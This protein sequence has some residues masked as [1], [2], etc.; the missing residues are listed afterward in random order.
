MPEPARSRAQA[1]PVPFA[2]A[3]AAITAL[4]GVLRIAYLQ[5]NRTRP[6]SADGFMYVDVGRRFWAGEGFTT[7]TGAETALHPPLW[8]MVLGL[9]GRLGLDTLFQQQLAAAL[10]GTASI[11]LIGLVGREVGGRRIGLA[12]A[13]IAAFSPNLWIWER[14]LAAAVPL[15][16]LTALAVLLAHRCLRSPSTWRFVALGATGGLLILTRT[17]QVLLLVLLVVGVLALGSRPLRHQVGPVAVA[18]LACLL[19]LAPWLVYNQTRF[20]ERVFVAT[21]AGITLAYAN[22]PVTYHGPLLGYGDGEVWKRSMM[23]GGDESQSDAHFREEAL[24][25]VGDNLDRLPVVIAARHGRTWGLFRPTQQAELD[26]D[27]GHSPWWTYRA[28]YVFD[29]ILVPFA[30]GGLVILRRRRIPVVLLLAPLAV[31]LANVTVTYGQTRYRIPAELGLI[32]LAAAGLDAL[33]RTGPA[34]VALGRLR[35]SSPRSTAGS[36]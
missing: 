28:G 17:E 15:I 4:G 35:S 10:I 23:V 18:A 6:S 8:S 14:E 12:A 34:T 25:Y 27:W 21:G 9:A 5:A 13:A 36:P 30:V 11:G 26:Q 29:W 7:F 24:E 19:V 3:L 32:V 20:E 22:S 31:A 33:P 2:L 16:P 1:I